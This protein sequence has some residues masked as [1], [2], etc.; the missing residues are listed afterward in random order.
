[1]PC[2]SFCGVDEQPSGTVTFLFTDI[3]S[4]TSLWENRPA[5]MAAALAR[6]D[7]LVREAISIHRGEVFSTGGDGFAAA[8][9]SAPDAVRAAVD[10]QRML[11]A[12]PWAR[13][14]PLRARMGL[15]TGEAERRDGNYFGA[16]LNRAA[17]L[18]SA[19]HGGQI[20][21]S[22]VTQRLVVDSLATGISLI[23][24]GEHRLRDLPRPERVFQVSGSGLPAEFPALRSLDSTSGNLPLEMTSFVGR[25]RERLEVA[26]LLEQTRM[27]TITGV[28]GVGKTR[29]AVAVAGDLQ[30]RHVDGSWLCE[31]ASASDSE[32]LIQVVASTLD[33]SPRP[34]LSLADS[35]VEALR[36]KD[37]LLCLD[38]CEH[39]LDP[40]GELS[41][42]ILARCPQVTLLATSREGVG[43][44]GEHVWPLRSL[45]LADPDASPAEIGQ[46][47]SVRLFVDRAQAALS[48]F[49]LDPSSAV[50]VADIC[51]RLDGIPLAIELAAARTRAMRPQEISQHL[52]E[53]FRLLAGGR[54]GAVE[55]HQ[56]LRA[57]VE[58][59]YSLLTETERQVFDQLAVFAGDFD[60]EAARAV[61]AGEA[62]GVDIGAWDVTDALDGL[63]SKS[64][65]VA[66][67]SAGGAMRYRLL[68]TLRQ[69]A[70]E[71]LVDAGTLDSARR[72]HAVHY[73]EFAAQAGPELMGRDELAWAMRLAQELDNVRAAVMWAVDGS[74]ADQQIA[75]S[76][77]ESLAGEANTVRTLGIGDWAVLVL[78]E[79]EK[80][81]DSRWAAVALAAAWHALHS[82]DLERAHELAAG[83]AEVGVP[84]DSPLEGIATLLMSVLA[85]IKDPP[86]VAVEVALRA[87]A[88]L[89]PTSRVGY[90]VLTN[91][92]GGGYGLA[93]DMEACRLIADESVRL[94]HEIGNPSLIAASQFLAAVGWWRLE[95]TRAAGIL[96]EALALMRAGA[97]GVVFGHALA[98]RSVLL[99]QDGDF[100]AH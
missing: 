41:V 32:G 38:N 19:A 72:R 89:P 35:V 62:A 18:M 43:V 3:E 74:E 46:A 21:V 55:R 39:L 44:T 16:T 88:E 52:D 81:R 5:A 86:G 10:A 50:S 29:L 1:M 84:A 69:Y 42:R 8:F 27:L 4:S 75:I 12:E 64:M 80:S 63:V 47:A 71:R 61:V 92:A 73:A 65:L 28:G 20:V 83:S 97:G 54:R 6:H 76:I 79:A 87:R 30:S 33:V 96:D 26:G 100:A 91:A 31:L 45:P 93:G 51:R 59:S 49:A 94:A 15:H 22:M 37:V 98:I 77:V 90:L 57:T 82:G 67:G 13:D 23:D 34:G 53:R 60:G 40:V 78:P 24:L 9:D 36:F 11:T 70:L 14:A 58:W 95:P 48:G 17:R 56:T 66:D 7:G 99:A 25:E 68:E 2:A 85:I